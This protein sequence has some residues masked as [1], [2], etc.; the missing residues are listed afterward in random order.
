M[1]EIDRLYDVVRKHELR[2]KGKLYRDG[3]DPDKGEKVDGKGWRNLVFLKNGKTHPGTKLWPT[4]T[5]AK[6]SSD[7]YD[8]EMDAKEAKR[9][10]QWVR[11]NGDTLCYFWRDYSHTIQLP[12][13]E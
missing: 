6:K 3:I 9:P 12:W 4:E 8:A 2:N 5:A 11:Y 1:T 7:E 10:G 13:R